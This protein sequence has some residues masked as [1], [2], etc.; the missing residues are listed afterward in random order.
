MFTGSKKLDIFAIFGILAGA[1]NID[2]NVTKSVEDISI[3]LTTRP[4]PSDIIT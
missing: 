3:I 1:P 2:V 4:N